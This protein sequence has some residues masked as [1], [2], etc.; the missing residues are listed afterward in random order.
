MLLSLNFL[1]F[2]LLLYWQ[3]ILRALAAE[4]VVKVEVWD[5]VD[6]GTFSHR[7]LKIFLLLS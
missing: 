2:C 7:F 1:I 6:K 5:V 4:D 3:L